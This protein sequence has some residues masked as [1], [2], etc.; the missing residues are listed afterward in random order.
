MENTIPVLVKVQTCTT[1]MKIS[2]TFLQKDGNQS[3]SM[4]HMNFSWEYTQSMHHPT[5]RTIDET[6]SLLLYLQQT[7]T[8]NKLDG[9]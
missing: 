8:V 7:E 1:T 2:M 3:N 5:T 9:F 4:I 6:F